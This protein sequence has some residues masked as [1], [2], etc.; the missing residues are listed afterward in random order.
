[1]LIRLPPVR[2]LAPTRGFDSLAHAPA[3]VANAAVERDN[4]HVAA[5]RRLHGSGSRGHLPA[6]ALRRSGR[7]EMLRRRLLQVADS[8]TGGRV[9]AHH[10][11]WRAQSSALLEAGGSLLSLVESVN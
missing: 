6:R 11:L 2:A 5:A 4:A 10:R 9:A 7:V 3:A 8:A 1:M